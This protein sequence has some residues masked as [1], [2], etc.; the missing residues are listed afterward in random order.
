MAD[1]SHQSLPRFHGSVP[2]QRR[3]GVVVWLRYRL[4]ER[5]DPDGHGAIFWR[6]D[7][8]LAELT[9]AAGVRLAREMCADGCIK[10]PA[11]FCVGD[12]G[13]TLPNDEPADYL[14]DACSAPLCS[15][16]AR[17]VRDGAGLVCRD[18]AR[19]RASAGEVA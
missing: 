5:L 17:Q 4:Y 11:R 3:D 9:D 8:R 10:G 1:G 6:H 2:Y 14:C 12:H 19:C 16:C 13:S 15:G 7:L 18:D